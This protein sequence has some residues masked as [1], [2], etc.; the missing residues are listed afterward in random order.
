MTYS[1]YL[2]IKRW[3]EAGAP[4][5]IRSLRNGA[6]V[7]LVSGSLDEVERVGIGC[8]LLKNSGWVDW[9]EID[10]GRE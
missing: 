9:H 6:Q 10:I 5:E 1:R 3:K 8:V 2:L 7:G 4:A